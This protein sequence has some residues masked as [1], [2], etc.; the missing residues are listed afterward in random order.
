MELFN[1]FL[2]LK[3]PIYEMEENYSIYFIGLLQ[4]IKTD[5]VLRIAFGIQ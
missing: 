3:R 5:E 4:E 1:L 2:C